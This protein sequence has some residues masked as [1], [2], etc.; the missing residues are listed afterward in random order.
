MLGPVIR[1]IRGH[2]AAAALVIVQLG[3]GIALTVL[4]VLIGDYFVDR[5]PAMLGGAADVAFVESHVPGNLAGSAEAR[6]RHEAAIGDGVAIGGLTLDAVERDVDQVD[7][8]D[9]FEL[10]A[11]P[12]IVAVAGFTLLAGR[13]FTAADADTGAAIVTESLHLPVGARFTSRSHGSS[14]VVGVIA[15]APGYLLGEVGA[16]YA[17][18]DL[19]RPHQLVLTRGRGL[20]LAEHV[21]ARSASVRSVLGVLGAMV[22]TIVFVI[23]IGS[24]GLTYFLVSRRTREIGVRRALGAKRRDI[25]GYFVLENLILTAAGVALGLGIV[26]IVAPVLFYEQEGFAIRWPLVAIS[27]LAVSTLNLI[28][29]WIPAR[30]AAAVPPV[31]ASRAA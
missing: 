12:R 28:A 2:R 7:G 19:T 5:N 6:R 26:A 24:M 31:V 21:R 4:A 27:T 9:A 18:V 10:D 20:S 17:H 15:D 1:G 14:V 3:I 16:I 23:V 8:V 11:G 13:D 29:T 25:V 30:K 22:V